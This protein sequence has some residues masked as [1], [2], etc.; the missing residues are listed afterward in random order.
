MIIYCSDDLKS[1]VLNIHNFFNSEL[2]IKKVTEL[3]DLSFVE[4]LYFDTYQDVVVVINPKF[5]FFWKLLLKSL[6]WKH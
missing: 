5:N 6:L 1:R 4:Q 2:T 3:W